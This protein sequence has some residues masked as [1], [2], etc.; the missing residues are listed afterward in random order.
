M[1][2]GIEY[3]KSRKT[4]LENTLFGYIY[5]FLFIWHALYSAYLQWTLQRK[6]KGKN[7]I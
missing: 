4:A 3:V 2:T 1:I 5:I 7:V 6:D